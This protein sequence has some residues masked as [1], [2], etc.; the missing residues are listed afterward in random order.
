MESLAEFILTVEEYS[1]MADFITVYI[2]EVHATD[3]WAVPHFDNQISNHVK[4]TG[5]I[6]AAKML[7]EQMPSC[8]V[9]VDTMSNEARKWYG[10]MPERLLIILDEQ[11][12]YTGGRGPFEYNVDEVRERLESLRK[13]DT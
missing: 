3:G 6:A 11:I 4:L 2:D 9:V 12:K 7:K 13:K 10:A 5:R 1:S 8:K